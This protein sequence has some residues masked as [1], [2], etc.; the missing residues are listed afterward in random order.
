MEII[1]HLNQFPVV[2][3]ALPDLSD[4]AEGKIKVSDLKKIN[5]EAVCK[6]SE[7]NI[8][9]CSTHHSYKKVIKIN[10]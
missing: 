8:V 4:L 1:K 10:S 9:I 6:A 3:R 7:N 2:I 5:I